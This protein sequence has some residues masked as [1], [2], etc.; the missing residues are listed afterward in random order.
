M[1]KLLS[2]AL[3]MALISPQ[4][5]ATKARLIALGMDELDNEG[6]YY[7]EDSRNIFLNAAN[8]NDYADTVIFEWGE[9]GL[10]PDSTAPNS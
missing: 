3:L 8:V 7:I 1:K 2:I 4:A 9:D 6:S 10:F 5:F